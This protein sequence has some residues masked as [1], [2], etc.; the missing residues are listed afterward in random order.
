MYS[1]R[2][3]FTVLGQNRHFLGFFLK[4]IAY[5]LNFRRNFEFYFH[6]L[7]FYMSLAPKLKKVRRRVCNTRARHQFLLLCCSFFLHV[8]KLL[9]AIDH[10]VYCMCVEENVFCV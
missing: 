2:S 5:F 8:G 3:I 9:R 4:Q 7:S 6:R 1:Q 10:I